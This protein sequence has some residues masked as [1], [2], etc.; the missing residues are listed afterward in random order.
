MGSFSKKLRKSLLKE[1]KV[2]VP[3]TFKDG[4]ART[5][6]LGIEEVEGKRKIADPRFVVDVLGHRHQ[7]DIYGNDL[8]SGEKVYEKKEDPKK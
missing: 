4:T 8:Y 3:I 5:V 6:V 7:V 2:V 1:N